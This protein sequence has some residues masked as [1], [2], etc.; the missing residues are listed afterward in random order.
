MK[1]NELLKECAKIFEKPSVEQWYEENMRGKPQAE[2]INDLER[3]VKSGKLSLR[4]ALSIA[5]IV[6]VQWYE[7][8]EGVS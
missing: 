3:G 4:D 2:T 8:F 6:G 7:K 5:L 1:K